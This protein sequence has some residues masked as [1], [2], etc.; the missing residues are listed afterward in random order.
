MN[1]QTR[2]GLHVQM[3][4]TEYNLTTPP[5]PPQLLLLSLFWPPY[6]LK[7]PSEHGLACLCPDNKP[8]LEMTKFRKPHW[9]H[10]TG[11]RLQRGWA[12]LEGPPPPLQTPPHQCTQTLF[13]IR[14]NIQRHCAQ[15]N[16]PVKHKKKKKGES[17]RSEMFDALCGTPPQ[18][19][20]Q[21]KKRQI[22]L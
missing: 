17:Q 11:L 15:Q 6:H 5:P 4:T 19:K 13:T 9:E 8:V 12:G 20:R 21:K 2:T 1:T 18:K 14:L 7:Y 3:L 10:L 16:I 22:Q